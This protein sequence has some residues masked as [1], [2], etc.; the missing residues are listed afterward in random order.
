[1]VSAAKRRWFAAASARARC[2]M[3]LFACGW[4]ALLAASSIA[5]PPTLKYLHPGGAAVGQSIPVTAAGE[6][7]DWPPQVWVDRAGIEI[8]PGAEKGQLSVRVAPDAAPGQYWVRLYDTQGA[9]IQRPFWVGLIP[10]LTETEPNDTP[11]QA[12][13]LASSECVVNGQLPAKEDVDVF[14]LRLQIGQTVVASLDAQQALGSPMDGV[15][16]I[17][18]SK[19]FVLAQNDDD[20]GLDPRLAFTAPHEGQYLVRVFAFPASPDT[21]ISLASRDDFV[22]RLAITTGRF[23]DY[24]FPLAVGPISAPQVELFGWNLD[25]ASRSFSIAQRETP[26]EHLAYVVPGVGLASVR[27]VPHTTLV[28]TEPNGL[29]QPQ[30]VTLPITVSARIQSA[31]D[32]DVFR[33]QATP[34]SAIRCRIESRALGFPMDPLLTLADDAGTTLLEQDDNSGDR[35]VDMLFNPSSAGFFRLHVRDR[36]SQGSDRHVYRLSITPAEPDFALHVDAAELVL[37]PGTPL[38]VNV[39]IE[40]RFGLTSDI[41]IEALGLPAGVTSDAVKSTSTENT[42]SAKLILNSTA[43]TLSA[44]IQIVGKSREPVSLTH[45]ADALVTGM[46]VRNSHLWLTVLKAP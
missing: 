33:F 40:R 35:D 44:P 25:P 7:T 18:D 20:H 46:T 19:G 32:V 12:L 8:Q 11:D 22:Y 28:E 27:C 9:T 16:Q 13:T 30:E 6:F 3:V 24:A 14:K 26:G 31:S 4:L 43:N 23:V 1:M 15:L 42:A 36:Y 21:T 39:T 17:L 37:T 2:V 5:A 38:E 34:G 41:Q 10:E 29:E 45:S